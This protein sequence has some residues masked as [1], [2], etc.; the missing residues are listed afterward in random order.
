MQTTPHISTLVIA[1]A[2]CSS[3]TPVAVPRVLCRWNSRKMANPS[4]AL[5]RVQRTG[6]DVT[7]IVYRPVA[8]V[9]VG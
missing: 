3:A 6:T 2:C 4:S 1:N 8:A 9:P 7:Q 5:V